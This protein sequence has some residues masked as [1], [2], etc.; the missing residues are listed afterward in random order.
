MT[1]GRRRPVQAARGDRLR[2]RGWRQEGLLRMLENTLENGERPEDLIIYAATGKAARDWNSY[3]AI[4]DTLRDLRDDETLVVQSGKPVARFPT[5]PAAPRVV[6]A[7]TNLVGQ[8]ATWETF[9]ALQERGLISYGQYTAGAWQYIGQQGVVQTTYETFAAAARTHFDGSLRG[10]FVVSAGLGG[11]SGAQPLAMKLHG[12]VAVIVEVD[13]ARADRRLASG[14]L[15]VKAHSVD[16]AMAAAER[17]LTEG[18]ALSVG[19][20]ANAA[21]TLPE[22]VAARRPDLLTDQTSAHDMRDGYIAAGMSLPEA[23]RMRCD[24]PEGY[25][26]LA[27]STVRRHVEAMVAAQ[28]AGS[29]VFEYGNAIRYQAAR[30]GYDRAGDFDGFVKKYIRPSFC[31]GKGP[32]RWVA[33]SGDENDI[34]LID[35]AIL[36]RFVGDRSIT[37][38]IEVAM[39]SIPH[40]GLPARSSWFGYGQRLAFGLMVNDMVRDGVLAGPVAMSR[41]HLDS[42]AVA[43]PTRET[44]GMLDGSDAVADWPILNAL[45]NAS[46]GADLVAVHQGAG[47]GMGGSISAGVTLIIDGTEECR[48]KLSR[49]LRTDPG[50]GVIRHADAGYPEAIAVVEDS[51][52]VVPRV[53]TGATGPRDRG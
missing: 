26:R 12:A 34:R 4:V 3:A 53:G 7:N 2:C 28:D 21:D 44:E 41:D 32:C 49:V 8:Y 42:G 14:Y 6:V 23:R 37:D 9:Y 18:S 19:L 10:R 52:L 33:L 40:Q 38:W 13:E 25:E 48:A 24:D 5:S 1:V 29:V 36:K 51:D 22:I 46:G 11:M 50:I 31:V 15:D 39:R 35:E 43:Q 17:A 47:S 30:A 45:L 27:L 16:E 20:I